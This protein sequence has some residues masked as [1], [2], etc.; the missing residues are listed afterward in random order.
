MS[1]K[2]GIA[3]SQ[4]A[5][6][7]YVLPGAF[8]DFQQVLEANGNGQITH[9]F[10]AEMPIAGKMSVTA[11]T[12]A[13]FVSII[14]LHDLIKKMVGCTG[15]HE[16]YFNAVYWLFRY[17]KEEYDRVDRLFKG[18]IREA[19]TKFYVAQALLFAKGIKEQVD[20]NQVTKSDFD[21]AYKKLREL[22]FHEVEDSGRPRYFIEVKKQNEKTKTRK[23]KQYHT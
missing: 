23:S 13:W 14:N 3:L 22:K 8:T 6:G 4:N 20:Y 10:N 7:I 16:K 11:T 18:Y 9:T 21:Y 5:L 19:H 15:E 17:D 1:K 2:I 12:S